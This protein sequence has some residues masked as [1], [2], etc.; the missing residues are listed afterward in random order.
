MFE[1]KKNTTATF[2]KPVHKKVSG[3]MQSWEMESRDYV[4]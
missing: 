3:K 1:K 4:N 2:P